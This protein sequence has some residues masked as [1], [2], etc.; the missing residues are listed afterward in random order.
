[1]LKTSDLTAKGL[2]RSYLLKVAPELN[3]GKEAA[4][5]ALQSEWS[6]VLP[7]AFQWYWK[8]FLKGGLLP[9]HSI[10]DL[11]PRPDG[12]RYSRAGR[13]LGIKPQEP[14]LP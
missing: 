8:P 14:H 4:L 7:L 12:G 1:M 10:S 13:Q 3:A 5:D 6:R 9:R 11:L 2:P